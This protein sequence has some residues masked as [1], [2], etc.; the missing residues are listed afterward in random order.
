M[1]WMSMYEY[2]GRIR[3][4][5]NLIF[6][7]C[8]TFLFSYVNHFTTGSLRIVARKFWLYEVMQGYTTKK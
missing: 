3:S 5:S 4:A 2:C 8:E 1:D 6:A 7:N